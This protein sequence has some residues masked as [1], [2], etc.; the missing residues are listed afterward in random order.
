MFT[1]HP[2]PLERID[3]SGKHVFQ[4][5]LAIADARLRGEMRLCTLVD[6]DGLVTIDN[7]AARV[8]WEEK[9][10]SGGRGQFVIECTN[11]GPRVALAG[12]TENSQISA[13]GILVAGRPGREADGDLSLGMRYP[14]IRFGGASYLVD[15]RG[16]IKPTLTPARTPPDR[17]FRREHTWTRLERTAGKAYGQLLE[18]V[19]DRCAPDKDPLRFWIAAAA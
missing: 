12:R 14:Q 4:V 2:H 1:A 10:P 16:S 3:I 5:D 6:G 11:G 9:Q 15:T 18:E 13:D 8:R 19:L 17:G 7:E